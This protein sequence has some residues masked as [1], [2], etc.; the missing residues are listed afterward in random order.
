MKIDDKRKLCEGIIKDIFSKN[1]WNIEKVNDLSIGI[2]NDGALCSRKPLNWGK[3]I[4]NG[5]LADESIR[6]IPVL[7]ITNIFCGIA[8]HPYTYKIY[9]EEWLKNA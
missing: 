8:E 9:D 2:T 3:N 5:L 6:E 4:K 7:E 1:K